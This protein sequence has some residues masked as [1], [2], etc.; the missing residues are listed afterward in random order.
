MGVLSLIGSRGYQA[1]V[2]CKQDKLTMDNKLHV[3]LLSNDQIGAYTLI[4][5]LIPQMPIASHKYVLCTYNSKLCFQAAFRSL[6]V[7]KVL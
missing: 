1:T 2:A 3:L 5:E 6:Q 4:S 7:K